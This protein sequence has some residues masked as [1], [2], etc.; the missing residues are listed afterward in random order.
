ML[1]KPQAVS[2]TEVVTPLIEPAPSFVHPVKKNKKNIDN[3]ILK[4]IINHFIL[5]LNR[6]EVMGWDL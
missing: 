3:Y 2:C 6:L 4:V 5:K 1:V